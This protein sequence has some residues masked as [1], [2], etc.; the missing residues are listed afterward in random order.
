MPAPRVTPPVLGT[1]VPKLSSH[2][3]GFVVLN[4]NQPVVASPLGS[5]EPLSVAWTLVTPE[6]AFVVT[7]GAL[8]VTKLVIAPKAVPAEFDAIAQ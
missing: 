5:A 4:R 7:V 6:A 3:P 1:R 8:K 2:E